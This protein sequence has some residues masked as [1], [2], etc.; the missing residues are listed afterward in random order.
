[1]V[2]VD[3][4]KSIDSSDVEVLKRHFHIFDLQEI[5]KDGSE[6]YKELGGIISAG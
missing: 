4:A 6:K 2:W 5:L 3:C 1:M